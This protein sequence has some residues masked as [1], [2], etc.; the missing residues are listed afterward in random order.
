VGGWLVIEDFDPTFLAERTFSA[1]DPADVALA[2]RAFT[3][4][5]QLRANRGVAPGWGRDLY[6]T[7]LGLGLTGV[8][9]DGQMAI[10]PGG[11][12]GARLFQANFAQ[13]RPA[14]IAAGLLTAAELDR[15]IALLDDPAFAISAPLMFTAWGRRP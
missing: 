6:R 2:V 11:S 10:Q 13:V 14:V 9:A 15:M 7:F 12:A 4:L 5:E 8:G 3:A 1:S